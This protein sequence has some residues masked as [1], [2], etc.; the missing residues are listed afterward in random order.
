[1]TTL[2]RSAAWAMINWANVEQRI[3][4]ATAVIPDQASIEEAIH[5]IENHYTEEQLFVK[6]AEELEKMLIDNVVKI[7]LKNRGKEIKRK[8]AQKDREQK[9]VA[10]NTKIGVQVMPMGNI[11][12]LKNMGLDPKMMDQISRSMMDQLFGKRPKRKKKDEDD[13]DDEDPGA[14][15]YL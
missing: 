3:N 1:M 4:L 9:Q 15:F 12:D 2:K 13:D 7:L 14:S 8:L 11:K 10:K 5:S 6:E